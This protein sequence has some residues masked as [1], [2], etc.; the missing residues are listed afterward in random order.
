MQAAVQGIMCVFDALCWAP[1]NTSKGGNAADTANMETALH[2]MLHV[3]TV[4][5]L[6]RCANCDK[7]SWCIMLLPGKCLR[8]LLPYRKPR[9]LGQ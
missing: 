2:I 8:S 4:Q 3:H 7:L 9:L 1:T 5:F 6:Q